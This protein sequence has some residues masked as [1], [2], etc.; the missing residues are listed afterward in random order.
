VLAKVAALKK[1][2]IDYMH[3]AVNLFGLGEEVF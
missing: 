3:P 1:L 2:A